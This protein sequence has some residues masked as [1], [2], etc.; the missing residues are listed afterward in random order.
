VRSLSASVA[1]IAGVNDDR[2]AVL[3][4]LVQFINGLC[5]GVV[6]TDEN[7]SLDRRPDMAYTTIPAGCSQARPGMEKAVRRFTDGDA[8]S[9]FA[10]AYV[11]QVVG[12]TLLRGD[13]CTIVLAGGSTP[14][15]LY[16]RLAQDDS[17]SPID[18]SR[19]YLFWGDERCVAP[20]DPQSNYAMAHA[21]LI[22]NSAIPSG[23]VVRMQGELGAEAGALAYESALHGFFAEGGRETGLR[24]PEFD[25]VLLGMGADGHTASLFPH[26]R[27]LAEPRRWVAPVTAPRGIMPAGRI[28]L[29]L[30]VLCSAA[31]V[32]FLVTGDKKKQLAERIAGGDVSA[33]ET[34]PA[35]LVTARRQL[36]WCIAP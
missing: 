26:A 14:R 32:L 27:A 11:R 12:E 13:R 6:C 22:G 29:T 17:S 28:T 9:R 4:F 36:V 8:L 1:D 16:V 31:A 20:D 10:A 23:N 5:H 2:F 35:S 30:P 24:Y 34:Y 25:L 3:E 7:S 15:D 21:S 33:T 18:W 19:V